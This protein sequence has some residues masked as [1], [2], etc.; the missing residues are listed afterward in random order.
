MKQSKRWT[1]NR[2]DI[3]KIVRN[4]LIFTAPVLI[5]LL[6]MLQQGVNDPKAYV[7]AV[8][9][10]VIGVAIDFIRKVYAGGVK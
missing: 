9:I 2:E 5:T 4:A 10:W 7:S 1:L 3:Q 8:Q 6:T